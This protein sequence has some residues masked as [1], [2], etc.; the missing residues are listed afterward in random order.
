MN[1]HNAYRI[2]V[3]VGLTYAQGSSQSNP[4]EAGELMEEASS[5]V[6]KETLMKWNS[7]ESSAADRPHPPPFLR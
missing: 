6:Y 3:S 1:G 2:I 4:T 7:Q 5:T